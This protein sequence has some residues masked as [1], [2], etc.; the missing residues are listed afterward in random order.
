M[1]E[2]CEEHRDVQDDGY[3]PEPFPEDEF[4]PLEWTHILATLD[5]CT[6][7]IVE[8][9]FCDEE[10]F[11]VQPILMVRALLP[12]DQLE[13][14][15]SNESVGVNRIE[16]EISV[17]DKSEEEVASSDVDYNP[18]SDSSENQ[19]IPHLNLPKNVAEKEIDQNLPS[20]SKRPNPRWKKQKNKISN[21]RSFLM[22]VN[23]DDCVKHHI[24]RSYEQSQ[25]KQK[26]ENNEGAHSNSTL[27]NQ[28]K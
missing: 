14:I 27:K 22:S 24:T 12:P 6:N 16:P 8:S 10:G 4:E 7:E 20:T 2:D 1:R 19:D 23:A 9:Q 5:I 17:W 18:S 21:K 15:E 3:I 25:D 13:P 28:P 26:V 11:D